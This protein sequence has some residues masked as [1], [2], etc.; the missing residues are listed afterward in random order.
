MRIRGHPVHPA[1]V[2]FPI[3]FW[4][5]AALAHVVAAAGLDERAMGLARL[6]NGAGLAMALPAMAAGLM[7]LRSIG[8]GSAAMRVATWH[9]TVMATVWLCF[10]V[11]LLL[12]GASSA[13][14]GSPTAQ[15]TAAASAVIGFLL[16]A[17]GGWLGGR[18]VYEFGVG[19]KGAPKS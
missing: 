5:V 17:V 12:S 10:L 19:V 11:A 13:V 2:H 14:I 18:L 4:T 3:A 6:A 8:E 16:M 7:E 1:L 15:L 9:L